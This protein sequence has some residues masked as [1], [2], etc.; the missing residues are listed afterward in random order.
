MPKE[1]ETLPVIETLQRTINPDNISMECE[2]LAS[3]LINKNRD[4]GNS[5]QEQFNEYGLTSILIRLD[6][7]LRRLKN[8]KNHPQHVKDE[9]LL[10]TMK[11]IA[12]YAIL[13][14]ICLQIAMENDDD[15]R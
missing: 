4:Y 7:K 9:S 8:L 6:D 3:L 12:G 1:M 15:D 10:D 5:V 2:L 11:D 14:S 13:G